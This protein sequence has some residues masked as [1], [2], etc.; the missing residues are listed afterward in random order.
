MRCFLPVSPVGWRDGARFLGQNPETV[1]ISDASGERGATE[2]LRTADCPVAPMRPP[3]RSLFPARTRGCADAPVA[4]RA[5]IQEPPCP[6]PAWTRGCTCGGGR[7]G[8]L[9]TWD[10]RSRRADAPVGG[11]GAS[12]PA[13]AASGLRPSSPGFGAFDS[14]DWAAPLSPRG[15][16]RQIRRTA[17]LD[18]A[19]F[20][21]APKG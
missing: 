13:G 19:V 20:G 1:L 15:G 2:D 12:F 9:C 17:D 10:A 3:A 8:L 16:R 5:T 7:A 6:L 18:V 14:S 21:N 11:A 4:G